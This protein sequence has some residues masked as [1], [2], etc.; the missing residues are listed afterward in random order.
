M[1]DH[2]QLKENIQGFLGTS[3]WFGCSV[4]WLFLGSCHT[5]ETLCLLSFHSLLSNNYLFCINSE[6][7]RHKSN[8]GYAMVIG[9]VVFFFL[10]HVR[11]LRPRVVTCPSALSDKGTQISMPCTTAPW[12]AILSGHCYPGPSLPW[13]LLAGYVYGVCACSLPSSLRQEKENKKR[14]GIYKDR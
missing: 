4:T 7:S 8:R 6:Q 12:L 1:L 11:K 14:K 9:Q 5:K 3:C 13:G 2:F 10:T